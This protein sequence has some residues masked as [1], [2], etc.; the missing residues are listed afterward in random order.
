MTVPA[1][2]LPARNPPAVQ[3]ERISKTFPGVN[4]LSNVS[5]DV[6]PGEVHALMGENG[7]GKSTL[8][9]V[10]SGVYQPDGGA[11]RLGGVEQRF[12]SPR[13]AQ[14][15]GI[16][17]IYQELTVLPNLDIGRNM[18]LGREPQRRA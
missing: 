18:L 8:M 14:D 10:L 15:A 1:L 2:N 9:K 11:I 13:D 7:A 5:F 4:A 16:R 6:L 12:R 17:M 3:L